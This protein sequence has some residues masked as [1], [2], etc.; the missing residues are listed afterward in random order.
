MST[1]ALSRDVALP[2]LEL[3]SRADHDHRV[4]LRSVSLYL[5]H[6][7]SPRLLLSLAL[8]TTPQDS[9]AQLISHPRQRVQP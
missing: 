5:H 2:V 1:V 4:T 7:G 8:M 6:L 9:L 3:Q